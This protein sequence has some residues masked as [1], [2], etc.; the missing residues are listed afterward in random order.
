MSVVG[1]E[2][3]VHIEDLQINETPQSMFGSGAF[4]Q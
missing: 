1:G 4:S 2:G 3:L